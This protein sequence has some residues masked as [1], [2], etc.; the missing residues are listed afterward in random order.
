M[1]T[2]ELFAGPPGDEDRYALWTPV[3]GGGE[4]TVYR[5]TREVQDGHVDV[6]VKAVKAT[7]RPGEDPQRIAERLVAQATR[8]RN[9]AHPGIVGVQEAFIGQS[10]HRAGGAQGP[11]STPYF[12][13]AWVEGMDLPAW[14]AAHPN[15]VERLA[16]LESV[17]DAL[18]EL[19]AAGQVHADVKPSNILVRSRQLPSGAT[20]D[21]AVL[22]D[23]GLMRTVTGSAS[24]DLRRRDPWILGA[25]S[26]RGRVL[27]RQRPVRVGGR[28]RV[29]ADGQ[30]AEGRQRGSLGR[31]RT[32]LN[33][34]GVPPEITALIV[35]ALA[36]D[37]KQRPEGGTGRWL[38]ELR[39]GASSVVTVARA[40]APTQAVPITPNPDPITGGGR[41]GRRIGIVLG[42]VAAALVL[43]I[44]AVAFAA[45]GGGSDNAGPTTTTRPRRTTSTSTPPST[46][47]TLGPGQTTLTTSPGQDPG[48]TIKYTDT[49][50]TG[51]QIAEADDM[52]FEEAVKINATT[53]DKAVV[54]N[55]YCGGDNYS[56]VDFDLNKRQKRF[57]AIAGLLDRSEAGTS[58]LFEILLD[59]RSVLLREAHLGESF[60]ID[61]DVTG[62]LRLRLEVKNGKN[63]T[64]YKSGTA[65]Y[66]KPTVR[67]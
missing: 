67:A 24:R 40:Q 13:M 17:A 65:G 55:M 30:P 43:G 5:S 26:C 34:V 52:R 37:P 25:R 21:V 2:A 57:T 50:L 61:I 46:T 48:T 18:D 4:G 6:A 29:P 32:R 22:V 1:D 16:V 64:S 54:G 31:A 38:A 44:A 45:K 49:P 53:Y 58:A 36:A 28:R 41:G 33:T 56:Y 14:A 11:V 42:A 7:A 60:P 20:V 39:R 3:G 63:C 12:V 47:T 27:A 10:P 59:N 15:P 62:V 9:F 8:L 35:A 51:V 19:H 66:A 23:F